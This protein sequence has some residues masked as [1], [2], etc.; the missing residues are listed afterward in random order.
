MEF[1]GGA[2]CPRQPQEPDVDVG[3]QG[4]QQLRQFRL[5][6]VRTLR[7]PN[8]ANNNTGFDL[9]LNTPIMKFSTLSIPL[10]GP[11]KDIVFLRYTEPLQYL[12][13]RSAAPAPSS[14]LWSTAAILTSAVSTSLTADCLQLSRDFR[15]IF[16]PICWRIFNNSFALLT[17]QVK[18]SK[19]LFI[20]VGFYVLIVLL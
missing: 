19:N 20:V 12:E 3:E 11:W 9:G 17:R 2:G 10:L 8:L 7:Y 14:S 15:C 1:V 13:T 16:G 5:V 6:V 4:I 18:Q